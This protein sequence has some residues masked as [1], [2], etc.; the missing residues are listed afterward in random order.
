MGN[1]TDSNMEMDAAWER[2]N[3][4]YS[5][6]K[7]GNKGDNNEGNTEG[8]K[9]GNHSG[10]KPN[11]V[12]DKPSHTDA[13]DMKA[14]QSS[15]KSP[16]GSPRNSL[17]PRSEGFKLDK[18]NDQ[19]AELKYRQQCLEEESLTLKEACDEGGKRRS[20]LKEVEK[21]VLEKRKDLQFLAEQKEQF[22]DKLD[23]TAL[24]RDAG[25]KR[26]DERI[27][28]LLRLIKDAEGK[29]DTRRLN[30]EKQ[31]QIH[32]LVSANT[33]LKAQSDEYRLELTNERSEIDGLRE[34][35]NA[36]I[37]IR[38]DLRNLLTNKKQV[39]QLVKIEIDAFAFNT[40]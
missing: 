1:V 7:G 35:L 12:V 4:G 20:R 3:A 19:L 38:Q 15:H 14:P 39:D 40:L 33:L 9:R 36:Y 28:E 21:M 29:Q 32:K 26:K 25:F 22:L 13:L 2:Y 11:K 24:E 23:D 30:E 34:L 18:L 31:L 6:E 10:V 37:S 16:S 5:G 8:K 17:S 27:A